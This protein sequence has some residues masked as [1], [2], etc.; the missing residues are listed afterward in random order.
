EETNNDVNI[1]VVVNV[2]PPLPPIKY[3]SSRHSSFITSF[4]N[5]SLVQIY[6]SL[7]CFSVFDLLL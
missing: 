6:S 2:P 7:M 3:S 4:F 5:H 1:E